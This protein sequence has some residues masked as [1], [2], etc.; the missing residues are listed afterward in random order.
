[1]RKPSPGIA[2][3]IAGGA[4]GTELV[5]AWF[6]N[7]AWLSV[8]GVVPIFVPLLF[9]N[10][11]ALSR[12]WRWLAR[13]GGFVVS[14]AMLRY[15][16][17]DID[18]VINRALVYGSLSAILVGIYVGIVFGFQASLEPFT[19]ESDLAI[20]G[21]TLAVAALFRPIRSR[22]QGFIDRR[23]Y[24]RKVDAQRT[25]EE[26]NSH[27]RDEVDLGE[28]SHRLVDVVVDTVQPAHASLWLRGVTR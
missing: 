10:G 17:Y 22:V 7:W 1:M 16:L 13:F 2:W 6:G 9:P 23:F 5:A 26:F 24:R 11:K 12:R 19:A 15:R 21:S 27:L 8:V 14:V 28:I 4:T 18:V 3:P 25:V 20:A